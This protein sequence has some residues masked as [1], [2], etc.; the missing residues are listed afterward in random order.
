MFYYYCVYN[1]II[2]LYYIS[3]YLLIPFVTLRKEGRKSASSPTLQQV[4]LQTALRTG[5]E[6]GRRLS[7]S[8]PR[9]QTLTKHT[10]HP[11]DGARL[12]FNTA[13]TSLMCHLLLTGVIHSFTFKG[14]DKWI[15]T[16]ILKMF[17]E[18]RGFPG[19]SNGKE[20]ACNT[21]DLGLTLV[22]GRFPAGR[23]GNPP[24][25]SCLENSRDRGAWWATVHEA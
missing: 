12:N 14:Q 19:G 23:H 2:A 10:A 25:Y 11:S 9:T 1:N 5:V 16:F 3:F 24:Q 20:H 18:E 22:S 6:M 7:S 4:T 8:V 13:H 17:S 15:R 21:G